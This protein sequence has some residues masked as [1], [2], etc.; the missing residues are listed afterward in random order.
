MLIQPGECYGRIRAGGLDVDISPVTISDVTTTHGR[1]R[2][3][4][5]RA[6]LSTSQF[7]VRIYEGSPAYNWLGAVGHGIRVYTGPGAST[8][9]HTGL[10]TDLAWEWAEDGRG[11]YLAHRVTTAG[12]LTRVGS[13]T[14]T[15]T[16]WTAQTARARAQALLAA[17]QGQTS[18]V[19]TGDY[20]PNLLGGERDAT[21]SVLD[22]LEGLTWQAE[23]ILWDDV[24]ADLVWQEMGHRRTSPIVTIP[25]C[26]VR[27][28]PTYSSQADLVNSVRIE[29]GPR[30]VNPRPTVIAQDNTST[31]NYGFYAERW[32]ADYADQTSAQ[33]K[34]T[35][36]VRRQAYPQV[37]LPSVTVLPNQLTGAQ[38]AAVAAL[39]VGDRV[40]L[41]S[42]PN[43]RPWLPY[44]GSMASVMTVEGWTERVGSKWDPD[45]EWTLD[46]HLSPPIWSMVSRRWDEVAGT[47]AQQTKTWDQIG[48]LT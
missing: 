47:W 44:N 31:F 25:E 35:R 24:N 19:Q 12:K 29:Y 3:E 4:S 8:L 16:T 13:A 48:A 45:R 33:T 39:R 10:I 14:W 23:A 22:D 6:A 40:R 36:I 17:A 37:V 42:L 32:D 27:W 46:L 9:R 38:W 20:D 28:A 34:A 2:F 7:T 26:A 41:P 15:A 18:R 30:D 21:R 43:P 5:G 1:V 11:R